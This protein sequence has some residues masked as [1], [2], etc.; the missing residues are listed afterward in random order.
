MGIVVV[1][2]DFVVTVH[3]HSGWHHIVAILLTLAVVSLW[4]YFMLRGVRWL[5]IVTVGADA[6]IFVIDIATG[7]GTW[8][9][10]LAA[11]V[12][13]SLLLL[14]V[15]RRFFASSDSRAAPA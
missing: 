9:G 8:Y 2:V 3:H 11:V 12:Q 4:P 10:D 1:A 15:T 7:N 5:W 14:P 13:L 6:L